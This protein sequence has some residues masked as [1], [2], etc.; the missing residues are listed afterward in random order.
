MTCASSTR[1]SF[2]T[3]CASCVATSRRS[4]P[5]KL[6][7]ARSPSARLPRATSLRIPAVDFDRQ[8]IE[9]RDFPIGRRGYDP[10]AVDMHLRA[11]AEEFEELQRAAISGGADLS[12]ASSAGTQGQSILPA[13]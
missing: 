4:V 6:R 13:A 7:T 2:A 3:S 10:A 9:R 8:A 1:H 11:L 12:L 5:R